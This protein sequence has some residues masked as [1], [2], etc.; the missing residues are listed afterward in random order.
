MCVVVAINAQNQTAIKAALKTFDDASDV[1]GMQ[2]ALSEMRGI[3]DADS[4]DWYSA[5]WTSFFFTQT[6]RLLDNSMD[7]YDSAQVYLDRANT[8][9]AKKSKVE[10]ADFH[11]LQA[12]IHSLKS[13]E[14]WSRGDR[15]NAMS[16]D[17]KEQI[18]LNL[19]YQA[20]KN[21]PRFYLLTGTDLVS[22]GQRTQ[23][24]GWILAG[25]EML[26][27]AAA[28]FEE[29]KPAS[30]IAPNWGSGWV[31]FWIARANVD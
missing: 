5:Y 19:A 10:E 12:L 21:N 7:Y 1:S 17:S 22:N 6:G 29:A 25:K 24:N 20:N 14:F 8:V 15:N 11:V 27:K 4:K 2:V 16:T 23:S 9:L 28:L 3:S 18:S 13:G 31:K 30:D 26:E